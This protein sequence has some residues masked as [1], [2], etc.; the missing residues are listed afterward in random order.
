MTCNVQTLLTLSDHL[1]FISKDTRPSTSDTQSHSVLSWSTIAPEREH[2]A[3]LCG[4][5]Q[6]T[7]VMMKPPVWAGN[8]ISHGRWLIWS[9]LCW[10]GSIFCQC[11]KERSPDKMERA[12]RV[13]FLSVCA[14]THS[15][16][17]KTLLHIQKYTTVTVSC[18]T[19]ELRLVWSW[20]LWGVTLPSFCVIPSS[21]SG[22]CSCGHKGRLCMLG[23]PP[24]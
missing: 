1:K 7:A 3:P 20:S 13:S 4:K 22:L 24:N 10:R 5:L 9:W 8:G 11:N 19:Y 21:C 23:V 18:P 16:I 15:I 2:V 6:I 14:Q 17:M 12:A